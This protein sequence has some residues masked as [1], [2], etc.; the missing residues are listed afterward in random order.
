MKALVIA[1]VVLSIAA[2]A[3]AGAQ[4]PKYAAGGQSPNAPSS[5]QTPSSQSHPTRV[6]VKLEGFDLA[7]QPS[8]ANQVGAGSPASPARHAGAN[9]VGGGSRG[10]GGVKLF[11]PEK[12]LAYSLYPTFQW[13]GSP[14]TK[15]KLVI[16][17]LASH[18]SYDVVVD[19]TS[20][21][22]PENAP[23]LKAGSTYSWTVQPEVDLM[24][25]QPEP[26]LIVIAGDPEREQI[27]A[28]LAAVSQSGFDGD[29]AR[30]Q[31]YF[32]KRVWYDAAAAYS[33]LI[34]A[35]PD[36][37]ELHK[38]RGTLYDQIP[39]TEKLADQDFAAAQ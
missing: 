9:Q 19:G 8:K 25:G 14:D 30:A 39:A 33:I 5:N 35:H 28:A 13:S 29:R 32:D 22:Y 20:F 11:A 2:V 24:G 18:A 36:D 16:E 38:M 23:P 3:C 27:G 37:H 4:S 10:I 1:S 17:D 21:T 31:V 15:Y 6:R 34:S 12:G 26:V 7:S